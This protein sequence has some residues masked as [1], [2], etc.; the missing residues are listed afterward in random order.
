MF[1]GVKEIK[2][3]GVTFANKD[4]SS[5]QELLKKFDQEEE[6]AVSL[7]EHEYKGK[8]AFHVLVDGQVIGN[9]P[10]DKAPFIARNRGGI[11]FDD[12]EIAIYQAKDSGN[13]G[14]VVY[15]PY[16]A[17]E[18][19]L[20][21]PEIKPT[22][23]QPYQAQDS[24][25]QPQNAQKKTEGTPFYK[26]TIFNVL[27]LLFVTPI[28]LFT[29]WAYA[30]WSKPVKIGVTVACVLMWIMSYRMMGQLMQSTGM[31]YNTLM[32]SL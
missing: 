21:E 15:I 24:Y 11:G 4:G 12:V 30:S 7:L 19:W 32:Q 16:E 13:Y 8:P 1:Q 22:Y 18:E 2:V 17:N 10:K 14:A 6:V 26:T 31:D 5:R 9:I 29:M 25:W 20:D 28:G 27:M 3:A 23:Q